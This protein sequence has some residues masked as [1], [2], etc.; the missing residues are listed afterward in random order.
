MLTEKISE[1]EIRSILDEILKR[2]EF[3][4]EKNKIHSKAYE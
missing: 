4:T 3:H 1:Q 2:R